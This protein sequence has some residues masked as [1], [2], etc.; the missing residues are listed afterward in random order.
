[1]VHLPA[2]NRLWIITAVPRNSVSFRKSARQGMISAVVLH[3]PDV[4]D[5]D[6]PWNSQC[7][8]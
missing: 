6:M 1:M 7:W 8:L 3:W 5:T 4:Q 2:A